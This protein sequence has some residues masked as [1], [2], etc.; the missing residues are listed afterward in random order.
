LKEREVRPG[1]SRV[2]EQYRKRFERL[3]KGLLG[4]VRQNPQKGDRELA[5]L[6]LARRGL[7]KELIESVVRILQHLRGKQEW[8]GKG[9]KRKGRNRRTG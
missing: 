6:F 1:Q 8:P 2:K 7:P 9:R 4:W 5:Q 3:K